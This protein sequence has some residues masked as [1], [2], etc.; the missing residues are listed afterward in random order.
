[1]SEENVARLRAVYAEWAKGDL[2]AGEDLY[3]E[4]VTFIPMA[5]GREELD[6]EGF[7]RFMRSFLSEWDDFSSEAIEI[8]D[9]GDKLLVT[10]HQRATGR[11]SGIKIDQLFYVVWTFRG[12]LAVSVRWDSDPAEARQA[13]GLPH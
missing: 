9:H 13:A 3:A 8:V 12:D 7:R 10:E 6:R 11:G 5:E 2:D 4:D 1:M